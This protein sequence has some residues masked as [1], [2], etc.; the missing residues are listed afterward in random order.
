MYIIG[1]E[2]LIGVVG[3]L[4]GGPLPPMTFESAEGV[5]LDDILKFILQIELEP[6]SV[7]GLLYHP[8]QPHILGRGRAFLAGE[9]SNIELISV[10]HLLVQ[11]MLVVIPPKTFLGR[12][13][14]CLED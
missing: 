8:G 14:R 6:G 2:C 3:A 9:G 12:P 7:S 13:H 11:L 1:G 10:Q 4:E 5:P